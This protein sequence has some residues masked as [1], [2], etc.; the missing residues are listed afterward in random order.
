MLDE[1]PEDLAKDWPEDTGNVD[2]FLTWFARSLLHRCDLP[3]MFSGS[4]HLGSAEP[5][6]RIIFLGDTAPQDD[7]LQLV[8][9]HDLKPLFLTGETVSDNSALEEIK[10]ALLNF[11]FNLQHCAQLFGHVQC[12]KGKLMK[13]SL[14]T[15]RTGTS[16]WQA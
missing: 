13:L 15:S 12:A 2:D 8:Q 3:E 5:C 7:M 9:Q 11:P 6:N 1:L 14:G 10:K 4:H 16:G